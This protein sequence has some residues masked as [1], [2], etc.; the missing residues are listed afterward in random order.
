MADM[1]VKND[2]TVGVISEHIAFE[3]MSSTKD[4]N[5]HYRIFA[6]IACDLKLDRLITGCQ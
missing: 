6:T 2:A 3:M 4:V 1:V 5:L